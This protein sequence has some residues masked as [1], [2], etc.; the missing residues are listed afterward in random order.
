MVVFFLMLLNFVLVLGVESKDVMWG[1]IQ[2]YVFDVVL[3]IYFDF[4]QVV[5]FVVS[6]YNDFVKLI[7]VYCVVNE[8]EQVVFVDLVE[9]LKVWDGGLDVEEL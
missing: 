7:K 1:F 2:C 5:G 6:Y 9:C 8:Q 4:D 3:E